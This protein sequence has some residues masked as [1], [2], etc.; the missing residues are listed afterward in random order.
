MYVW[1]VKQI[2]AHSKGPPKIIYSQSLEG[3]QLSWKSYAK[4]GL[5]P[6][7]PIR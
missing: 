3:A 6:S 1:D 2:V 7:S 5:I 4:F